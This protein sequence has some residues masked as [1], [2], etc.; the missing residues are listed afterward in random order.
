MNTYQR[1]GVP[2]PFCNQTSWIAWF[3]LI[4]YFFLAKRF[5]ISLLTALFRYV[6]VADV[7]D[8]VSLFLL[9]LTG[10]RVQRQSEQ[11]WL[12]NRYAILVE[13]AKRPRLPPP[14]VVISY[15]SKNSI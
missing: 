3:L 9:S 5:L 14:F 10:A 4:Q 11:I 15:A 6:L 1:Y 7:T 12:Y 2:S 13:Y 8:I